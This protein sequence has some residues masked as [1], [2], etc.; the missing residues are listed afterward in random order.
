ML[1]QEL[2]HA[3]L[4]VIHAPLPDIVILTPIIFSAAVR[5]PLSLIDGAGGLQIWPM[6]H[7]TPGSRATRSRTL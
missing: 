1:F 6:R 3:L 2:Q 5:N 4:L 7:C